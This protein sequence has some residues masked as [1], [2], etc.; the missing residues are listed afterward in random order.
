MMQAGKDYGVR[1]MRPFLQFQEGFVMFPNALYREKLLKGK[2]VEEVKPEVEEPKKGFR[3][4]AL[5]L[6]R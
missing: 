5:G 1:V 6:T 4:K 3:Q 2:W